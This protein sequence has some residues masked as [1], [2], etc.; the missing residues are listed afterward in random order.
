M[1][2]AVRRSDLLWFCMVLATWPGFAVARGD[3]QRAA[4][5]DPWALVKLPRLAP[6]SPDEDEPAATATDAPSVSDADSAKSAARAAPPP[7]PLTRTGAAAGDRTISRS[8]NRSDGGWLRTTASL[9]AVIAVILLLAWGYRAISG[10]ARLPLRRG[11]Q[12]GA[13]EVLARNSLSP[14]HALCLVRVGPRLV[15]IG[16]SPDRLTTLDVLADAEVA[17]RLGGE[18]ARTRSD[19]HA[20]E[21]ERFLDREAQQYTPADEVDEAITPDEQRVHAIRRTLAAAAARL[22]PAG[23]AKS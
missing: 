5:D 20:A 23:G 7:R 6:G 19:S 4:A 12:P 9:A 3:E 13:L 16:V 15:L 21:F 8:E 10:G 14:R 18:A 11:R 17:A 22:A 1:S 2:H